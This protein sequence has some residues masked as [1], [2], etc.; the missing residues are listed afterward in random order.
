MHMVPIPIQYQYRIS[1]RVAGPGWSSETYHRLDQLLTKLYAVITHHITYLYLYLYLYLSGTPEYFLLN[2]LFWEKIEHPLDK[3]LKTGELF[4]YPKT[5]H[6]EGVGVVRAAQ[7][8]GAALIVLGW[9]PQGCVHYPTKQRRHRRLAAVLSPPRRAGGKAKAAR[10]LLGTKPLKVFSM[11]M[12]GVG[13][14][15]RVILCVQVST[16]MDYILA[17]RVPKH[18]MKACYLYRKLRAPPAAAAGCRRFARLCLFAC[19][20][21]PMQL[22]LPSK[23][24]TATFPLPSALFLGV[25]SVVFIG[26]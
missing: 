4:A 7:A 25:F 8:V 18:R 1:M 12:P 22:C 11:R 13:M 3:G 14:L 16:L 10:R 17:R 23:P 19:W 2:K 9:R 6:R 15:R 20:V 26:N 5:N 24:P 21:L